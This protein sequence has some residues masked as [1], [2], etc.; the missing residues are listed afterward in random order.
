MRLFIAL[1]LVSFNLFANVEWNEIEL[2]QELKLTQS[3]Q[4]KQKIA[5]GSLVDIMKGEQFVVKDI[6]GLDMIQV[7]LYKLEYKNCPGSAMTTDMEII[8]VNNTSP[9]V[10][11]GAQLI[12]NCE[13]EIFIEL[14]D[15]MTPSFFE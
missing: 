7:V 6:I 10:E 15:L 13:L 2:D 11:I 4:L 9:V 14:K 8:P 12:E 3:F 1:M 5:A